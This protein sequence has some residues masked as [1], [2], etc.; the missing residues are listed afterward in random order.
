M[1]QLPVAA[2]RSTAQARER[3][4]HSAGRPQL[5]QAR[6]PLTDEKL[7]EPHCGG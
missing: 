7:A 4:A 1:G 2:S 5:P 3:R 6:H